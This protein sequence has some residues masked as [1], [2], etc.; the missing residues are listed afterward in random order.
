[1]PID[2]DDLQA[3]LPELD[4]APGP[5]LTGGGTADGLRYTGLELT[6]DATGARFLECALA[7]CDVAGVVFDRAR[8]ASCLLTDLRSPDW[9]LV[10]ATLLDVVASGGRFGALT[11]HGAQ[12]TRVAL[13]GVKVD[14]VN[15]RGATA[16]DLTLTGCTIGELDLSGADLRDVRLAG[17][18]IGSLVLAGT[19]NRGVDLRG[20]EVEQLD[21]VTGLRGC[22][23]SGAQLAGWSAGMAAELGIRVG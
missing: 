8:L 5:E 23:I 19:R 22:T 14:F 4:D 12:L 13:D 20:A 3:L 11:A 7:D 2:A 1:M 21:G 6:G 16:V 18:T 9:S 10:G 17:C 15:L